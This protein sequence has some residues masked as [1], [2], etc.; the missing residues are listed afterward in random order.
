MRR[1]PAASIQRLNSFGMSK[2]ESWSAWYPFKGY[3]IGFHAPSD[4]GGVYCIADAGE[5]PVYVGMAKNLLKALG[6]APE[7]L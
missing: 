7:G 1:A 3:A 5:N 2:H 6:R 4:K